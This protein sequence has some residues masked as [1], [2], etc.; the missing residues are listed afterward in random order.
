MIW[1]I[2]IVCLNLQKNLQNDFSDLNH[3]INPYNIFSS[4]CTF[5]EIQRRYFIGQPNYPSY[6]VATFQYKGLGNHECLHLSM[7]FCNKHSCFK[8]CDYP[9]SDNKP[10]FEI[11][12]MAKHV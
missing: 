2:F 4:I 5:L 6:S 10:L 12:N 3:V 7:V 8:P 11:G 1:C 9:I